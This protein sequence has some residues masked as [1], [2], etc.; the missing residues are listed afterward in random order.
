MNKKCYRL[1]F[2]RARGFLVAVAEIATLVLA[3]AGAARAQIVA[4]PASPA[5]QRPTVLSAP[6]GVPLVNIQAPSAAGV[7]RNTYSR[8]D[9]PQAGAILN[10]SSGN[11]QTQLGGWIQGNPALAGGAARVILN[12][13]NSSSASVLRGFLEVAGQRADVVVANPAG[14]TIDGAGFINASRATL[15]TG[16]PVIGPGGTLDGFQVRDGRVTVQ[17]AGLDARGTDFTAI[18]ARAVA[19][20]AG[21]WANQL[22]V[23]TGSAATNADGTQATPLAP[24]TPAPAFAIDTAQLGGMYA[25]HIFLVSTEAGVGVRNAGTWGASGNLVLSANGQLTTAGAISA[26]GVLQSTSR[27]ADN[28]GTMFG[29]GG[30]AITSEGQVANASVIA[31]GADL[32]IQGGAITSGAGSTIAAGVRDDGTVGGSGNLS[33]TASAGDVDLAGATAVAGQHLGITAAGVVRTDGGA[34]SAD[35]VGVQAGG[36]SNAQGVIRSA[37]TMSLHAGS[38]INTNGVIAAGGSAQLATTGAL[39]NTGGLIQAAGD[40]E[41]DTGG[42]ALMNDA[43]SA[44]KGIAAGGALS[45]AAGALSNQAGRIAAVGQAAASVNAAMVNNTNGLIVSSGDLALTATGTLGN[46]NGTIAAGQDLTASAGSYAG[47]GKFSAQR[48]LAFSSQADLT[49]AGR[50]LEAGRDITVQTAGHLLNQGELLASRNLSVTADR[51]TN[52]GD[53]DAGGQLTASATTSIVNSGAIVGGGVTLQAGQLIANRGV[54]ALIGATDTAGELTLLAPSIEN[55]DDVTAVDTLAKP[56]ILGLGRVTLAGGR[57]EQGNFTVAGSVVNRSAIIESGGDMRIYARDVTNTRRTLLFSGTFDQPLTDAEAAALGISLSGQVGTI[58]TPDPNQI[59]GVYIDPPH[60]G[61]WNSDYLYTTY[62]GVAMR[63]ALLS[64]SPKAQIIAGGNLDTSAGSTWRNYWSDISAAGSIN[65]TGVTLDQ[66]GWKGA[67][68]P[69]VLV[70]YS[71]DYHYRTYEGVWWTNAFTG[72]LRYHQGANYNSTF[73][74]GTIA[75]SGTTIVNDGQG[76]GPPVSG[77]PL[78]PGGSVP[79]TVPSS[80]LFRP[81]TQPGATYLVE[82]DPRFADYRQWVSSNYLLDALAIDPSALQKRLGDGFY[83]QRLVREQ[84]LALTGRRFLGDYTDEDAQYQGLLAN[85][86]TVARTWNLRP[87][88]ALSPSQLEQLTSDIV[89]LVEQEVVLPSGAKTRA[90]VPVVYLAANSAALRPDGALIAAHRIELTDMK[91]FVNSGSVVARDSLKLQALGD[92]DSRFGQLVAGGAMQLIAGG[93]VDLTGGQLHAGSLQMDVGRNLLLASAT[94]TQSGQALGI[95]RQLTTLAG[96]SS[97]DVKG[98]AALTVAGDVR[99]IGADIKVGGNLK[100]DVGGSWTLDAVQT[101]ESKSMARFGGAA[102]SDIDVHRGSSVQVGGN[103]AI[104]VEKDFTARGATLELGTTEN[105]SASISAG[106]S[107]VLEAVKDRALFDSSSRTS[108]GGRVAADTR[109]TSNELVVGTQVYSAGSLVVSAG[110]DIVVKG[111]DVNAQGALTVV[112][113]RDVIVASESERHQSASSNFGSS[114]GALSS[115]QLT[116]QSSLDQTLQRS[117]SLGGAQ[118]TVA[119]GRDVRVAGSQ[120]LSDEQTTISAGRDVAIEASTNT[121]TT[122]SSHE[123]NRSGLFTSGMSVTYGRRSVASEQQ[124]GS[125]TAVAS[126]VGSVGG[127]VVIRAGGEYRQIGS[128]VMAPVGDVDIAATTVK[129]TEARETSQESAQTRFSQSGV[130]LGVSSPVLSYAQTAQGTLRSAGQTSDTRMQALGLAAAAGQA[131]QA[132][133]ALQ[134]AAADP[135]GAV[136]LSISIGSSRSQ[137]SQ[138]SQS[139]TARGSSISAGGNVSIQ[140]IGAGQN[141]DILAQGAQIS[142]GNTVRLKAD[143]DVLLKAAQNTSSENSS[144]SSSSASVGLS[145]GA[146]SGVTASASKASGSGNGQSLTHTNTHVDAGQKVVIESGADTTLQGAVVSASQ[147]MASVGGNLK[148]ESLHDTSTYQS[149]SKSASGSITF[150][151]GVVTG[152]SISA[153]KSSIDSNYQ[154][155]TEQSAIRAGDGGFQVSVGGGTTLVGGQVTSTQ[156]AIDAAKNAFVSLEGITTTDIQ[157]TASYSGKSVGVTAGLGKKDENPAGNFNPQGTSF[158]SGALQGSAQS[159]SKAAISGVAGEATARTGDAQSGLKPIFDRSKVQAELDARVVITGA[160]GSQAAKVVGDYA[161]QKYVQ[162]QASGDQAGMAAWKEGG[163][164]R[165]ALHATLGAL[166]G[167]VQGA[168]GAGVSQAAVDAIGQQI[169]NADISDALKKTLVAVAGTAIGAAA[170]GV[171]GAAAAFNATTNNYLKHEE[172]NAKKQ[173]LA[174]CKDD[175]CRKNVSRFWDSVSEGRNADLVIGCVAGGVQQCRANVEQISQDL[176]G[177]L[178]AEKDFSK[179]ITGLTS[180]ER[181]NIKQAMNQMATNLEVLAARGNALLGTTYSDPG[182]LREAGYLNTQEAELLKAARAGNMVQFLGAVYFSSAN[183]YPVQRAPSAGTGSPPSSPLVPGG[184]LAAHE[185]AGGHLITR[186][187]GQSE[188]ALATRLAAEPR[189]KEAS[190]FANRAEAE[191][192]ISAALNAKA[193]NVEAWVAAGARGRLVIDAPFNGGAVLRRGDVAPSVGTGVRAV[194]E[195]N[196]NGGWRIVTGYPTP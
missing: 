170:G 60:S 82:T 141:S 102:S 22:R 174:A 185:A 79:V 2:S 157:N 178:A 86:V 190:T 99:Q 24:A 75:G 92:L 122:S 129:I 193:V 73:S 59:G 65:L 189:L 36:L 142:A 47:L 113:G 12:E 37:G 124:A 110:Q 30:V 51:F 6:N 70:N 45:I 69:Q 183:K 94:H 28:S 196:G 107:V 46:A 71:G 144:S 16:T 121:M 18:L 105:H 176:T 188:G 88:I 120:V 123:E 76:A 72:D 41:V 127:D 155:V 100:A 179:G 101:G 50:P 115:K 136:S 32:S 29:K 40:L 111:S 62:N 156:A 8:F 187:I 95:D 20:N 135:S 116:E 149:K 1:V 96:L 158:G 159:V 172:L 33:L 163:S 4:D 35:R 151:S 21:V 146:G 97:I 177:L 181:N 55:S 98:D 171:Q 15:T 49:L 166:T 10:N 118:V 43:T 153:S 154:S 80:A 89:W 133:D 61:Q 191:A 5:S 182:E 90:L 186:H 138:Q 23:V 106:G 57:D 125:T 63:N 169:A 68:Q 147:V 67:P 58:N 44:A 56:I 132:V 91:G 165:V 74:A 7:S 140:A 184:G 42:H 87:G 93:N 164:A 194:L 48:D 131:K 112:A 130:S 34:V 145:F 9:V 78:A 150:G 161:E 148:I 83:E 119:A 52:A 175:T 134:K 128:D 17:G 162:A 54:S 137:S 27:G 117:A 167:G 31:S 84:M 126:T 13:V 11:V 66:D 168:I 53:M 139:D 64:I 108:G 109:Y 77:G 114:K 195:G 25:G 81:P 103:T 39:T 19:L 38:L 26:G 143:G 3:G 180:E 104:A 173:Q 192:A 160:F 85:A 152:A 14:I